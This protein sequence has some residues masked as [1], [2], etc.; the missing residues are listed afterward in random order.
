MAGSGSEPIRMAIY[1]RVSTSDQSPEM[2]LRELREMAERRGWTVIDEYVDHGVSGKTA[3]RPG[4]DRLIE[5]AGQVSEELESLGIEFFSLT[6]SLDTT[7]P[8]GRMIFTI[9]GAIAEFERDLARERICAGLRNAKAKGK[10]IGRP[11]LE[12]SEKEIAEL[13]ELRSRGM[14][15]RKIAEA[16]VWFPSNDGPARHPSPSLVHRWIKMLQK[17]GRIPN[18]RGGGGGEGKHAEVDDPPT[19]P[20]INPDSAFEDTAEGRE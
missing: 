9:L 8:Q 2:Q 7:T 19:D 5:Q 1:A 20:F 10:R 18:E 17:S 12:P 13:V 15:I 3:R 4:L 6:E 16:V 11:A 14:S